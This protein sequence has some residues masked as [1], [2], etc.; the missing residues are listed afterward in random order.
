MK[1]KKDS[2]IRVRISSDTEKKLKDLCKLEND[3]PSAVVRK[4]IEEYV[5]KHPMTNMNLEVKLNISKLPESNPHRWY[6]FNLEAE[7]V[8][9]YSYLDNE[10]VTFL[11]PEFYDN[12]RE[13]YRVDSVY[14]HRESFPK[15]IGKRGRFIGAKLINRKWK[16]AIYVYHDKL[17][18]QPDRYEV[19]IKERMKEQIIL[20]VYY[21]IATK[22]ERENCEEFHQD[23][24]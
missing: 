9:G 21:F 11:L 19:D 4:L 16:G 7:L 22:I 5:E 6:V 3:T 2:T 20:G 15:C 12:S 10:E 13:P 17:L 8:G 24:N 1:N 23:S 18:E 14:Y